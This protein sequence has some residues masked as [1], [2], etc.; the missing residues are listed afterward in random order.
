MN[1][2]L[3]ADVFVYLTFKWV[4]R[5]DVALAEADISTGSSVHNLHLALYNIVIVSGN[6]KYL[7]SALIASDLERAMTDES[8]LMNHLYWYPYF[9][10]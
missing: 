1:P 3:D 5:L 2:A 7:L 4:T 8:Y 9:I 6:M 10:C